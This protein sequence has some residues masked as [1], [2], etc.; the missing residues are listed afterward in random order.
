[1]SRCI[2]HPDCQIFPMVHLCLF[3]YPCH[4][5]DLF[6]NLFPS[7]VSDVNNQSKS[8]RC[9]GYQE[10]G[11]WCRTAMAKTNEKCMQNADTNFLETKN[12]FKNFLKHWLQGIIVR[13]S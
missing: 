6:A 1:M 13:L 5:D 11:P 8:I 9:V 2:A 12:N 4:F 10:P 7:V 3:C